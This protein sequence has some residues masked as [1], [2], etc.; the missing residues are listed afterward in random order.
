MTQL[1]GKYAA[2]N[3]QFIAGVWRDGRDSTVLQVN[4]PFDGS[5]LTEIVQADREDLDEAYRQA[6]EAQKQWAATGPAERAAV[7]HRVV[8]I[9]DQR[10]EEII[11]WIIRESGSTRLKA[12]IEWGA[13]RGITLESASFPARVHG[14]ILTSNIPGKE[15]R[16]YREPLGVVGVISPWN[17]PLHLSQRSVAPA[18]ALGNAVVIKPASDTPVTGGLLLARIYEEA[19]LPAG[20]LS[21]LVGSG[22]KI[23]DAFVDHEVPKFISFT[24]STPVGLNIGRLASGGK[25]LKHVALELGGN[26]P[27]VVLADADLEQAVNAAV[28][29]KFLHQG[30]ICMAINRIIVE[31]GLYEAFVTRYAQRV[32]TLKVGDPDDADTVIG[33]I[34]NA[35]QL[36]GLVAKIDRAKEEGAKVVVQ[37]DVV[38]QLLPPHVFADV[39]ADMEIAQEEIFGPLV[40]IQRAVDEAHAL[41]LANHSEFGLSSAVFTR[42]LERGVRFARQVKA[43]MTHVN[44][45]PV[46]DEAHAPFGGEKNSGLGRFNGEWAIEEFTTDHWIS[47]QHTPRHYPF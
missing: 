11:D 2:F 46:N 20:L 7:L 29:G 16:V 1:A 23:G 5:L 33:P 12:Q 26:S 4:N 40:G 32:N 9:F 10:R 43:G 37:G 15:S 31:D 44:D 47:V 14:R 28:M 19:G 17:F 38:G 36:Q 22:A 39:T 41:E 13:A 45:I 3:Q 42:D 25:H 35:R 18:L 24:G 30:Q 21:V 27:F 34:I 8:Q 6:A